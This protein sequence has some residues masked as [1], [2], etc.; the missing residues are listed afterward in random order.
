MGG[1]IA[2]RYALS[3]QSRLSGLILSGPAL[4]VGADEPAWKKRLLVLV[5]RV[6]P[7]LRISTSKPGYLS[8]AP[9][10][11]R[12]FAAD[13]LCNNER[14]RLG[15]AR[16][17][18]LASEATRPRAAEL[19]LPLLVMHGDADRLASVRGSVALFDNASSSD[20]TLKLW[21][22]NRHEIFN[23]LDSAD[24]IAFMLDWL[25]RR[26]VGQSASPP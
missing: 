15:F 5:G 8:R 4:L 1:L 22:D 12:A 19:T 18:Y 6:L 10:V 16:A 20:K 24:V 26:A 9:E 11:E 17:L 21:P 7:N 14:T 3:H 25:D 23:D 13:P 2:T